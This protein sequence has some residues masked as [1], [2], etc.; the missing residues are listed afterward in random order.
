MRGEAGAGRG[1]IT[2]DLPWQPEMAAEPEWK[3][4]VW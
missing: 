3:G 4:L 1:R 2:E